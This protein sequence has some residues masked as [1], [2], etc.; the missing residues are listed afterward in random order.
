MVVFDVYRLI[1]RINE[2][3]GVVLVGSK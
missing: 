2:T 1:L 3:K